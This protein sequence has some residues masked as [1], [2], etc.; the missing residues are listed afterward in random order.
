MLHMCFLCAVVEVIFAPTMYSVMEGERVDVQLSSS[1]PAEQT[2]TIQV[3]QV[4]GC[5]CTS[6]CTDHCVISWSHP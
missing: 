1:L 6:A 4:D 3:V 2:Y 5:E